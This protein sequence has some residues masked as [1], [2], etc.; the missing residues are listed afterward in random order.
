MKSDAKIE[1]EDKEREP[2]GT[3]NKGDARIFLLSRRKERI[4]VQQRQLREERGKKRG[5]GGNHVDTR[6]KRL[7]KKLGRK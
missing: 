2:K 3:N 4:K 5:G 6:K 1:G 7:F